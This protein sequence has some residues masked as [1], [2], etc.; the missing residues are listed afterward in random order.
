V[1]APIT[2]FAALDNPIASTTP[3]T[4]I[5]AVHDI[6]E[7]LAWSAEHIQFSREA[8]FICADKAFIFRQLL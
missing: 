8:H 5:I 3:L 1:T 4:E 7:N 2:S 6:E